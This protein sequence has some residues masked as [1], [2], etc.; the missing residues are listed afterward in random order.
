MGFKFKLQDPEMIRVTSKCKTSS[1]RDE[2]EAFTR[3]E[4]EKFFHIEEVLHWAT[5][6]GGTPNDF[7]GATVK[8]EKNSRGKARKVNLIECSALK[9]I[10]VEQALNW[11]LCVCLGEDS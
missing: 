6:Q 10:G 7:R 1:H 11:L 3:D 5:R 8:S 2:T 9:G 4:V